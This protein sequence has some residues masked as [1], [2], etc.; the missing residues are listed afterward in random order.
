MFVIAHPPRHGAE[1]SR[2]GSDPASDQTTDAKASLP[3]R[4][5]RWTGVGGDQF[6]SI[7]HI[8]G[9]AEHDRKQLALATRAEEHEFPRQRR[10]LC[11][12]WLDLSANCL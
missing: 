12:L 3:S 2:R 4:P 1:A 6:S 11:R 8:A 9:D 5:L 10:R 7:E